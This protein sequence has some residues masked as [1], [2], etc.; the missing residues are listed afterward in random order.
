MQTLWTVHAPSNG[1]VEMAPAFPVLT[2]LVLSLFRRPPPHLVPVASARKSLQVPAAGHLREVLSQHSVLVARKIDR[3]FG[4]FH[5]GQLV[6]QLF[7]DLL[8]S[9]AVGFLQVT[10]STALAKP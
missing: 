3:C 2:M 5:L 9:L 10:Q 1:V 6:L 8:G 7:I 4:L